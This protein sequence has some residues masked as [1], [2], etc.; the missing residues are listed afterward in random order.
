ML[1]GLT[2]MKLDSGQIMHY[3]HVVM[4]THL[5]VMPDPRMYQVAYWNISIFVSIFLSR[6]FSN[7]KCVFHSFIKEKQWINCQCLTEIQFFTLLFLL[8]QENQICFIHFGVL[9][10]FCF[11]STL[12][13]SY[14]S[15]VIPNTC[16]N[17][18]AVDVEAHAK[19][20][21]HSSL[22]EKLD[23]ELKELDRKL[24]QKEVKLLFLLNP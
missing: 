21:E 7:A 6:A 10:H 11:V 2:Q 15:F 16:T 17:L 24:E 12:V 4:N 19:E 3:L 23:R 5:M 18:Y 1:I 22:Q 13:N 20:L 8:R 9:L 14:I